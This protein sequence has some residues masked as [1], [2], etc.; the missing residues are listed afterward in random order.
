VEGHRRNDHRRGEGGG[1]QGYDVGVLL[2]RRRAG[3][4]TAERQGQQEREEDLHAGLGHP[5]FLQQVGE[6]AVPPLLLGLVLA[7]GLLDGHR[8]SFSVAA[9]LPEGEQRQTPMRAKA[10]SASARGASSGTQWPMPRRV[11]KR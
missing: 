8:T 3:E 4:A 10:T 5:Q 1:D 9:E 6:V 7:A 2:E 11:T